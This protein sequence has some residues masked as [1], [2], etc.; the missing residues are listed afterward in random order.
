M[1]SITPGDDT[2]MRWNENRRSGCERAL[3]RFPSEPFERSSTASTRQPSARS[4]ST[5]VEP[6]NPAP[7]VTI[8]FMRAL[9]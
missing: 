4:R 3:A 1:R 7:P 8:A 2:S 9:S 5:S 6:M